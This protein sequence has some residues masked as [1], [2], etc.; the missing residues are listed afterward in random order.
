M[1]S[2]NQA[3]GPNAPPAGGLVTL[4]W[5]SG[6]TSILP[7]SPRREAPSTPAISLSH[8]VPGA[9]PHVV[10]DQRGD[11][12]ELGDGVRAVTARPDGLHVVEHRGDVESPTPMVVLVHGSLDRGASFARTV[13]R[14][15]DLHVLT[16]DRRGYHHSRAMP[17]ARTL[18][19]HITDLVDLVGEGPAVV[20]GHSYGGDVALGAAIAAPHAIGAVGAYEPPLPWFD[21][22]PRRTA[23]SI[24][25]EDPATFAEGFFRRVVGDAGWDRRRDQARPD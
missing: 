4:A 1:S 12:A 3:L 20:V 19:A 13:R 18:D 22:W 25:D 15:G 5:S 8:H 10:G 16:Y 17:L 9:F 23:S 7:G 6:I 21:W 2:T 11:R 24:A 14:L